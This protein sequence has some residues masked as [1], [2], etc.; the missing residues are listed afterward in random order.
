VR[1]KPSVNTVIGR[2][3]R[4]E[5]RPIRKL[6]NHEAVVEPNAGNSALKAEIDEANPLMADKPV[7]QWLMTVNVVIDIPVST[8]SIARNK[9][10]TRS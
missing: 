2:R 10:S 1:I 9:V 7:A 8:R 4:I 3:P 5:V 6:A